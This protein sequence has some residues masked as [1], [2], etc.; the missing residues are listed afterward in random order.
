MTQSILTQTIT[1]L[2]Q[3]MKDFLK[4]LINNQA[5]YDHI[6]DA[7]KQEIT[8]TKSLLLLLGEED[9]A[10]LKRKESG[11]SISLTKN[12]QLTIRTIHRYM[13]VLRAKK[14]DPLNIASHTLQAF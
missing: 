12:E 2:D 5:M 1:D 7:L 4:L 3:D 10:D 9:L 14:I 13:H 11:T 8:V 6:A